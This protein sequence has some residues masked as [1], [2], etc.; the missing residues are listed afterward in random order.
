MVLHVFSF[1]VLW[2]NPP[3]QDLDKKDYKV[4]WIKLSR[5]AGGTSTTASYENTTALPKS[6]VREQK[7]AI[8]EKAL[9]KT[10]SDLESHK[11]E[12]KKTAP[13]LQ[14]QKRT[15]ENA[16]IKIKSSDSK[17]TPVTTSK[18]KDALARIDQ[19]LKQREVDM[20]VAQA[21]TGETGQSPYG[22][23]TGTDTDPATIAYCNTIE[24]MIRQK[25]LN[26]TSQYTN[27]LIA[28]ISVRISPQGKIIRTLIEQTSGNGSF[29][30]SAKRAIILSEPYPT[31]PTTI[32][33][34]VLTEGI[35]F[36]FSPKGV[37]GEF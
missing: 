8:T 6:T 23:D 22:S 37:S 14:S 32:S 24:R 11:T 26:Y 7:L 1:I 36:T 10:G 4:T 21:K 20:S 29:D 35:E 25:W 19:D 5:G 9:D 2:Y 34:E 33:N 15:A 27:P 12:T 17:K 13:Q 31:P 18:M 16:G 3:G 28:K 30:E